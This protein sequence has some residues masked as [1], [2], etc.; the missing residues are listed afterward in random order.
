MC[1]GQIGWV[2]RKS[3]TATAITQAVGLH[4]RRIKAASAQK[5]HTAFPRTSWAKVI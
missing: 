4:F 1:H 3:K 2:K 5:S